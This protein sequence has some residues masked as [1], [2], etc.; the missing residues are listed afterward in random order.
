MNFMATPNPGKVTNQELDKEALSA[1]I[2]FV[3]ELISLR[4]LILASPAWVVN[5]FPL[6]LISKP[7]QPGQYWT[8][9][10]GKAGGKNNVCVADP[11]HMT[12]PDH[13][14]PL[15]Y[16][17][18]FSA[19]LDISKYFHMFLTKPEE[20][21]CMGITHLSTGQTYVYRTPPM[22]TRNSAGASGRFGVAFIRHVM[23]TSDFFG[24]S[25]SDNSLQQYFSGTNSH[26]KFGEGRV[27]FGSD[28]LPAVLLWLHVDDIFIHAPTK[29]KLEAALDHILTT[30]VRLGLIYHRSKTDPPS[31]RVKCCGF[32]YDTSS[33]PT[34]CIPQNKVSRAI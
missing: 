13:I 29:S 7:H 19:S 27:L 21:K 5:T 33:T 20:H 25:P 16:E 26:P 1:A 17:G 22:G 8:I 31:Q 24:G 14:L 12:S 30:T 15:L 18:G 34:L 11:C 23:E 10:D 2:L 3:D 28:G 4:V 9:A 32:E 6:F